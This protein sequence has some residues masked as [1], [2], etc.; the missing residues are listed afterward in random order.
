M[1]W[2]DEITTDGMGS[3]SGRL[4]LGSSRSL[5]EGLTDKVIFALELQL[6][7]FLG[8]TVM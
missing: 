8:F 6:D 2:E 4:N 5:H 3:D 7:S 1:G